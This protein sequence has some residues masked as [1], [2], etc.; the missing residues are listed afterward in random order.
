MEVKLD[1]IAIIISVIAI[2]AS[3]ICAVIAFIQNYKINKINMKAGYYNKIFD[4]Y[5]IEKIPM[6]Y[7]Y[8][9]FKDNKLYDSDKI[10]DVLSDLIKYIFYFK[11]ADR[12]F[13]EV[14]KKSIEE[15]E[16][17]IL[18]CGNRQFIQDEQGK[19]FENIQEKLE[20]LYAIINNSYIGKFK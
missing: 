11:C 9:I 5:L 4:S 1:I 15:I 20:N 7:R 6:S 3:V 16:D 19:V 17:Y 14:L 13:Y 2:L 8:M 12:K 18:E 10:S